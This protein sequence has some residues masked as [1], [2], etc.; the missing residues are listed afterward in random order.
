MERCAIH[1][2]HG[3]R[4]RPSPAMLKKFSNEVLKHRYIGQ[5]TEDT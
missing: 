3:L 1:H 5:A 4:F 2:N